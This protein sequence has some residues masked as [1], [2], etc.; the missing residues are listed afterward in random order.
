MA[1][2]IE[3]HLPVVKY[4]GLNTNT[5]AV[6]GGT[7]TV[8]GAQSFTGNLTLADAANVIV[9]STTGSKIATATTQ[10]LGFFNATPVVQPAAT[11]SSQVTSAVGST[12]TVFVNTTF[13]GGVGATAYAL[14]DVIANLKNLGILA[15]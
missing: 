3:D 11:G 5:N 10:K 9:G 2:L 6:F 13:T 12:T 7:L 1:V 15:A 4:N 8:T 14:A